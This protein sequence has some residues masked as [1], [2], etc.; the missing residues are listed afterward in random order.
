MSRLNLWRIYLKSAFKN[1]K[2]E[3][4]EFLLIKNKKIKSLS[5]IK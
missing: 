3:Y 4:L 2:N 1:M 5:H